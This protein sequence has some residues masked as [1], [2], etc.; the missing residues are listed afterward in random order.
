VS[1]VVRSTRAEVRQ[2]L[3]RRIAAVMEWYTGPR[4]EAVDCR[5]TRENI[6]R[7]LASVML[8]A[9]QKF[10]VRVPHALRVRSAPHEPGILVVRLEHPDLC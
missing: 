4:S 5:E 9:E 10:R 7:D 8:E 1:T 3:E 6:N 2:Y